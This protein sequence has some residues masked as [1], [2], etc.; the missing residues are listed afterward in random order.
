[1]RM[2]KAARTGWFNWYIHRGRLPMNDCG[3]GTRMVSWR[4]AL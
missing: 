3:R 4:R 1:M 2:P